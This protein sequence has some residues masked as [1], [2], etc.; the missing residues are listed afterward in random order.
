MSCTSQKNGK[1]LHHIVQ[2]NIHVTQKIGNTVENDEG[3]KSDKEEFT[4]DSEE[5]DVYGWIAL[6]LYFVPSVMICIVAALCVILT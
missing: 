1:W 6:K 3:D 4:Y 2:K 5:D